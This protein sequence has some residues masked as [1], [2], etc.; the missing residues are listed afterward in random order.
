VYFYVHHVQ[1]KKKSTDDNVKNL[2][3]M[4]NSHPTVG[5]NFQHSFGEMK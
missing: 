2:F 4:C 1:L 5:H 3:K